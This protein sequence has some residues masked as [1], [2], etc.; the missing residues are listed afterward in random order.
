[1]NREGIVGSDMRREYQLLLTCA[2][3][4]L[5]TEAERIRVLAKSELDFSFLI[6]ESLRHQLAP[7]LF[8]H[9]HAVCPGSVAASDI[10]FLRRNFEET[11][12][13]SLYLTAQLIRVLRILETS[14]ISAVPYKGPALAALAYQNLALRPFADLDFLVRQS[15]VTS[16]ASL[17]AGHGYT[18][19]E[20]IA[21]NPGHARRGIPGQYQCRTAAGDVLLEFHTEQTLRYFPRPMNFEEVSTRLQPVSISGHIV[22]T[23]S[24]E[25]MLIALCVHGTKHVWD[26]L[27]WICDVAEL[28]RQADRLDWKLVIDHSNRLGCA[29]MVKL[30]LCLANTL[31]IEQRNPAIPDSLLD[32][33]KVKP[34]MKQVVNQLFSGGQ[35]SSGATRRALFR[36]RSR[37]NAWQGLRHVLK[38]ATSPADED[39]EFVRLPES[40][41]SVYR[42]IRPFRLL[43]EYGL[44]AMSQGG[45]SDSSEKLRTK[46]DLETPKILAEKVSAGRTSNEEDG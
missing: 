30:G 20:K 10:E 17:L 3:V 1:M 6:A 25:D 28:L 31:L 5:E 22:R 32:E 24:S 14:G 45:G 4:N 12:Q 15:D 44:R 39:W 41:S 2:R 9:L 36:I 37:E 40:L 42:A 35:R 19:A 29:R 23:F 27:I 13:R 33:A 26:R 18:G 11:A 38:V 43:R 21:D 46:R 7:L 8:W 34:L 16:C